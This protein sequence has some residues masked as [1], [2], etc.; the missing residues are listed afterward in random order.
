M[1][2]YKVISINLIKKAISI[3]VLALW[4]VLIY[5]LSAMSGDESNRKSMGIIQKDIEISNQLIKKQT[6][7]TDSNIEQ[8]TKKVNTTISNNKLK[9]VNQ[10]MRKFMHGSVYLV[11]CL[12][13]IMVLKVFG[14]QGNKALTISLLCCFLYACTDEFHQQFVDGRTARFIDILIDTAGACLGAG[15]YYVCKR[16]LLGRKNKVINC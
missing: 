8:E 2:I 5:C 14:L 13:I 15:I 11:L 7:E 12:L 6:N 10:V 16:F 9:E 3:L 1:K 4:L